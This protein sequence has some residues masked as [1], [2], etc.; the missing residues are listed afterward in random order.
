MISWC[1]KPYYSKHTDTRA[2]YEAN[3]EFVVANAILQ[4][5]VGPKH[6]FPTART[7]MG[8]DCLQLFDYVLELARCRNIVYQMLK[9]YLRYGS[10]RSMI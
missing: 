1:D 10:E 8:K 6:V 2:K 4:Q 5:N 3:E 7:T 9:R